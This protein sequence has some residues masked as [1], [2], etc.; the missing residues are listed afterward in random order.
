MDYTQIIIL[1]STFVGAWLSY[2]LPKKFLVPFIIKFAQRSKAKWDDA[3]LSEKVLVTACKL[4]PALVIWG[5]T[6]RLLS[7]LPADLDLLIKFIDR[8]VSLYLAFMVIYLAIAI[9]NAF[10]RLETNLESTSQQ[11]LESFIGVLKI[12]VVFFGIIA[13][14]S[15]ILDKNPKVLLAGLGATS[16]VLMLVFKDTLEGLV[17]GIRLTSNDMLRKGDWITVPSANAD[18]VV[19]EMTLSTVKIRNFDNTIITISPITLIN[20]SFQN[21]RGM[22]ETDGRRVKRKVYFDFRSIRF[23]KAG[24]KM[25]GTVVEKDS[26]DTNLTLYRRDME[27]YLATCPLVNQD[28]TYMVRQLEA[29]QS[30]LPVE[31]YFFLRVQEWKTY[32]AQLATL[33]EYFYAQAPAYG[34]KIYEQFPVQ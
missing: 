15:I 18:G 31:F 16:A 6:P 20:G 4:M 11:Y 27:R 30:G 23:V 21:W 28:M 17:A 13:I 12:V 32:E 5:M 34:L 3:F 2:W 33:L 24:D 8:L 22:S 10:K 26:Q 7:W 19:E 14:V 25:G 9:I 1:V 29:T